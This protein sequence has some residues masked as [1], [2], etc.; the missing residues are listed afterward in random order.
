MLNALATRYKILGNVI[1][2]LEVLNFNAGIFYK[3]LCATKIF[4]MSPQ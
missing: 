2:E 3:G 4:L 1:K